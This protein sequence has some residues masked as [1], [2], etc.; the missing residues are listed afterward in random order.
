MIIHNCKDISKQYYVNSS[1]Q[2]V[3]NQANETTDS[4]VKAATSSTS[5]QILVEMPNFIDDII[6]NEML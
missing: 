5:F 6:T 1:V 3:R 2:F 4:L